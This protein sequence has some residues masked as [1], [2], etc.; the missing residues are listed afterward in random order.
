MPLVSLN[1]E[2]LV[3]YAAGKP[4][5]ELEHELGVK[6]AVK[7]A[8]NENPLGPSPLALRALEG[9]GLD[10]HQYP[11]PSGRRLRERLAERHGV[12]VQEIALGAGS[13]ELIDLLVRTFCAGADEGLICEGTFITY[14]RALQA[15]GI[16]TVKVPLD[17]YR[18]DLAAMR[19][20]ATPATKIVFLANPNNPTGTVYTRDEFEALLDGLPRT[21]VVVADE[22]YAE[23]VHPDRFASGLALRERHPNLIVLRTFSK[24]YGLAGMRLGYAVGPAKL[25]GYLDRVRLPF[26][27]SSLAQAAGMAA[28]DDSAHV[29]RSVA[30]VKEQ[31]AVLRKALS[32][33]GLDV[34]PTEANFVFVDVGREADQVFQAL[35]PLGVIVRPL[36]PYGFSRHIRVTIGR[37]EENQR[38]VAA[39]R[40]VLAA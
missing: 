8:S 38:F 39:L 35:L 22:A 6:N 9:A 28:L 26:N 34:G 1:I 19:R 20:A 40:Q 36:G 3:P 25:L 14:A 37:G 16:R 17:A 5:E 33:L 12:P 2:T 24:I 4:I 11:D 31:G 32:A 18:Y 7:L 30:L 15:A 10:L 29:E 27:V 21:A 13:N 23:Y